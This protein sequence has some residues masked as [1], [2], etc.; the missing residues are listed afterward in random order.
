MRTAKRTR[1]R[2]G[3][4][5]LAVW[6]GF[7]ALPA[8]AADT[9]QVD[10]RTLVRTAE[11]TCARSLQRLQGAAAGLA[12]V[13]L[14][15]ARLDGLLTQVAATLD[16]HDLRFFQAL[17]AGSRTLAELQLELERAG[18]VPEPQ[19]EKDLRTLGDDYLLLRSRYG[20]EWVRFRSGRPLD[21][22]ERRRFARLRAMEARLAG[23]LEPLA[24]RAHAA[25]DA[26]TAGE[27]TLL[28]GQADAIARAPL[29]LDRLLDASVLA[30]TI[31][32]EWDATRGANPADD[33]QWRAADDA[34]ESL[35]T[36]DSVGY[37][38]TL[39]LDAVQGWKYTQ[40][41]TPLTAPAAAPGLLDEALA[42]GRRTTLPAPVAL[43]PA[44]EAETPLDGALDA[45]TADTADEPGPAPEEGVKRT[46]E[47]R[48]TAEP[49][50]TDGAM[51]EEAVEAAEPTAPASPDLSPAKP[52]VTPKSDACTADSAATECAPPAAP[53]PPRMG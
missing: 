3:A 43:D 15:L 34:V 31:V 22:A 37:V 45:D 25:G 47:A 52:P 32:G 17:R 33:P 7:V 50:D 36:D 14:T 4:R 28:I 42:A 11:Q 21:D 40:E 51:E 12:P 29:T 35:A 46:G 5:V 13:R 23:R 8:L 48:E 20:P 38:F 27:L 44:G 6:L 19:V 49:E 24:Q 26:A 18:G 30:D 41:T 2:S 39:D 16:A 1:R 53:P 9:S 10:A